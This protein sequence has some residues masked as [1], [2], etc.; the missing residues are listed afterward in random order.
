MVQFSL[1]G[2][3]D[4]SYDKVR[5]TDGKL[6]LVFS[7]IEYA[8]KAGLRVMISSLPHQGS[9]A[10]FD[11]IIQFAIDNG[12]EELRVQPLMPLGRG[13]DA[14]EDL[15]ISDKQYGDLRRKLLEANASNNHLKIEWGDPIDHFYM[16]QEVSYV[17]VL[18]IDA[19]G[20]ILLSPYLPI[21][22]WNLKNNSME[23]FL[24]LEIPTKALKH[25]LIQTVLSDMI[26]VDDLGISHGEVPVPFTAGI[27]DLSSE[28]REL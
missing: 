13:S 25:P 15:C 4:E 21:A 12:L 6:S 28:I 26:S 5:Q 8:Q 2:I 24:D 14:F 17:P 10:E 22:I 11:A 18:N 20:N 1:D 16:L 27:V 9:L 19:Y 7:A 3:S 23:E